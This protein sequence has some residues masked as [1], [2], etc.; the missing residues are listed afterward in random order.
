MLK[1]L[2][3]RDLANVR[4]KISRALVSIIK[5][6]WSQDAEEV[7]Q[8]REV[9]T[10][11]ILDAQDQYCASYRNRMNIDAIWKAAKAGLQGELIPRGVEVLGLPERC[12]LDID[13][14]LDDERY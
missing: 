5:L 4:K 3:R 13:W 14:F 10:K 11:S 7:H 2:A 12:P 6:G 8:W 9:A 1:A